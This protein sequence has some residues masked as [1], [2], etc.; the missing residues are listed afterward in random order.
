M[1]MFKVWC[2]SDTDED[3]ADEIVAKDDEAAAEQWMRITFDCE[4]IHATVCVRS[5]DGALTRVSI[6]AEVEWV[7]T[8][9]RE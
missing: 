4:E 6:A 3:G 8:A 7:Y 5:P 1:K 2:P 9:R